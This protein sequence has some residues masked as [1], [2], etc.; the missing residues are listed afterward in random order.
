MKLFQ[1]TNINTILSLFNKD[2]KHLVFELKKHSD[3]WDEDL[4]YDRKVEKNIE[5]I[6][7]RNEAIRLANQILEHYNKI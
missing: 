5:I 4:H 1:F 7:P 2:N 6:L 3:E